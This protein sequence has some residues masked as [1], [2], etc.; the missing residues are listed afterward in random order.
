MWP[1]GASEQLQDCFSCTD[2]TIFEDDNIDT[3]TSSVL[4]YIK[5]CR[6]NVIT[7]KR[8]RVFPNNKPWMTKDV[9][10]LLKARNT[11]FRSGDPQQYSSAR[12]N[13]KKDIKDAKAAYKRKIEDHFDNSDSHRAW[14]GIR[15]ITRQDNTSSL[16]SSSALMAEQLNQFFGRFEVDRTAMTTDPT[17]ATNSQ[18]LIIQSADVIR[19]LRKTNTRKAAGPDGIPGRVLRDCAAE[20]GEVLTNIFNLSL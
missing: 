7:M 6:D 17:P 15:H 12:A 18:A 1:E 16:T 5:C 13:L 20:L 4:C 8:I 2:W 3:Y 14:Q 19:T 11:A 10:L 9:Q